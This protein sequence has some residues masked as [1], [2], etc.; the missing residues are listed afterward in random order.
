MQN[1]K[2]E[3]DQARPHQELFHSAQR[4]LFSGPVPRGDCCLRLS[5]P[6]GGPK[7]LRVPGQLPDDWR[8]GGDEREH[9]AQVC[10][11][12][13]GAEP[14][15]HGAHHLHNLGRPQAE[16]LSALPHPAHPDVH[17]PVI[18]AADAP[19]GG[20]S[21][22]AEDLRT[23][24]RTAPDRKRPAFHAVRGCVGTSGAGRSPC[25]SQDFRADLGRFQGVARGE[26]N[27][28]PAG[29][30]RSGSGGERK[31]GGMSE[32]CRLWRG[33]GYEA[34]SDDKQDKGKESNVPPLPVTSARSADSYG[35]F[36]GYRKWGQN[37]GHAGTCR[38]IIPESLR[39]QEKSWGH[40]PERSQF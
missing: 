5:A 40:T 30:Q 22:A 29:A 12:V 2:T 35:G 18:R 38:V 14:H 36:H 6:P 37:P 16:R 15:P 4:D 39:P 28:A 13:R 1:E 31:N 3:L 17:Q 20:G 32:T 33:E 7:N 10:D 21:G 19:P 11:G 26:E 24:G 8:S 27:G 23:Y 34:R 25:P 9:G